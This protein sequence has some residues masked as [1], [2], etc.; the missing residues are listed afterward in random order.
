MKLWTK[1]PS[2]TSII[3]LFSPR[4]VEQDIYIKWKRFLIRDT[5]AW[6][7]H[8]TR[9]KT[10]RNLLA[11]LWLLFSCGQIH[12]RP[13][14]KSLTAHT[15]ASNSL[16]VQVFSFNLLCLLQLVRSRFFSNGKKS[17]TRGRCHRMNIL[18]MKYTLLGQSGWS[19]SFRRRDMVQ[20]GERGL[21]AAKVVSFEKHALD[22]TS[23]LRIAFNLAR[24]FF[25]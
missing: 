5:S 2:L 19:R 16:E 6:V 9:W 14:F 15:V 12:W 25:G 3:K 1:I 21:D 23:S 4:R 13:Q 17:S 11:I 18:I 22:F 20:D 24:K 7:H 10:R 8:L